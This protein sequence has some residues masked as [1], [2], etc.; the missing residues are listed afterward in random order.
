[1]GSF[2]SNIIQIW[3]LCFAWLPP[4]LAALFLVIL[5]ILAIFLIIKLI[6][7]ILDAIPFF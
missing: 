4:A 5:G 7:I 3:N 6:A 1:M 2:I